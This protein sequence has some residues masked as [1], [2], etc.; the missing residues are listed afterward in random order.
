MS[1]NSKKGKLNG[2]FGVYPLAALLSQIIFPTIRNPLL[3]AIIA[4]V[5][6]QT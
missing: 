1:A 4:A 2:A 6:Q 5:E 3:R